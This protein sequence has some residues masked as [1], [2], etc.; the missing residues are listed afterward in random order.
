MIFKLGL[1]HGF[2]QFVHHIYLTLSDYLLVSTRNIF[3]SWD[4]NSKQGWSVKIETIRIVCGWTKSPILIFFD[5]LSI[6]DKV[7]LLLLV[8]PALLTLQSQHSCHR[9]YPSRIH[10]SVDAVHVLDHQNATGVDGRP[11]VNESSELMLWNVRTVVQ[12]HIETFRILFLDV[13]PKVR[14]SLISNLQYCSQIVPKLWWCPS[15]QL[16]FLGMFPH[17]HTATWMDSDRHG[18]RKVMEPL[19]DNRSFLVV[20]EKNI[21]PQ[22]SPSVSFVATGVN[23]GL[24]H[25]LQV[26]CGWFGA[27]RQRHFSEPPLSFHC[28]F[29]PNTDIDWHYKIRSSHGPKRRTWGVR[30]QLEPKSES[31]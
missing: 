13:L 12:K 20:H 16:Q 26:G 10:F 29:C 18:D 27:V 23:I 31:S 7:D 15:Q 28:C 2:A 25:G 3:S 9:L 30:N 24:D 1:D 5:E 6:F 19:V 4:H 8:E 17:Q 21:R 22:G 14:I 11:H